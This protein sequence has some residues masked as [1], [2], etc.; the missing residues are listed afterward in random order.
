[1]AKKS[2]EGAKVRQAYD[3]PQVEYDEIMDKHQK[4]AAEEGDAASDAGTRRQQIGAFVEKTGLNNKAFSQFRAG[5][6]Q[7]KDESR[8]DWLRSMKILIPLAEQAIVGNG[9][10][11]MLESG[12]GDPADYEDPEDTP[13][14]D[15]D[16]GIGAELEDGDDLD[17]ADPDDD[18]EG[19]EEDGE[20]T[21]Q[22]DAEDFEAALA[23]L[24]DDGEESNVTPIATG[25]KKA[26]K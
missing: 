18:D 26:A 2:N 16:D 13:E 10:P 7:K 9:T 21:I 24:G 15:E 22:D 5:M 23:E 11:D 19:D 6:K 1:M 3:G 8:Q 25:K 20:D 17:P 12:L 4:W 14:E